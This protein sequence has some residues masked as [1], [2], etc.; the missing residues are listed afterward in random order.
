[1]KCAPRIYSYTAV[2]L[3]RAMEVDGHGEVCS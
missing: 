1:M 2:V 3:L